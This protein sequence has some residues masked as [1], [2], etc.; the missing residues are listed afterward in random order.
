MYQCLAR[1]VLANVRGREVIFID[2]MG[3][4]GDTKTKKTLARQGM[5]PDRTRNRVDGENMTIV[6]A[7]GRERIFGSF[8]SREAVNRASWCFFLTQLIE[9]Y[10]AEFPIAENPNRFVP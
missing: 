10:N 7:T 9:Q 2:E 1:Q 5:I 8:Y 3:A 6:F 4:T